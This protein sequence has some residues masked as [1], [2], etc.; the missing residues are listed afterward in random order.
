MRYLALAVA[1]ASTSACIGAIE[2]GGD[3]GGGGGGGTSGTD[4]AS[5]AVVVQD[6]ATPQPD[7]RVLFTSPDGSTV[8]VTTDATGTASASMPDGGD[9]TIIRT[10]P[11]APTIDQQQFPEILTYVGVRPGDELHAGHERDTTS[12]ASA[13][14]VKVPSA[15]QGTVKVVTPCGGG[16]GTAPNVAISTAGCPAQLAL[17]VT[18]GSRSSFLARTA[19]EGSIDLSSAMLVG[20]LTTSLSSSNLSADVT[21]VD[22]E[23]R[24]VDGPYTLYSSG[25][26]RVDGQTASVNLPNLQDAEELVVATIATSAGGV[27][28]IAHRQAYAAT[29]TIVDAS[30][31]WTT[32]LDAAPEAT[33]DA[34]TWTEGGTGAPDFVIATV[35]VTRGGAALPSDAT[36]TRTIIAPHGDASLAIPVLG[37]ADATYDPTPDDKLSARVGLVQAT[38][39]YDALRAHALAVDNVVELAPLGGVVTLSYA[40]NRAPV[41]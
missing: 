7:V 5:V 37:G 39:G 26:K 34:I 22:A 17:Y 35:T 28:Q 18:D 11:V 20:A 40:A 2:T 4:P 3:S 6:G 23:A 27:Q 16:E 41:R 8:T 33:P 32:T 21:R 31:D 10:F 1:L 12:D 24:V 13:I 30:A 15:A 29:P 36:Y 9:V 14:N 38:G 25:T 19:Y